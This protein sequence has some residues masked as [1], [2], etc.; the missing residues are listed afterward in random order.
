[1]PSGSVGAAKN[2]VI[3]RMMSIFACLHPDNTKSLIRNTLVASLDQVTGFRALRDGR[4]GATERPQASKQ[5]N[6]QSGATMNYVRA[7]LSIVFRRRKERGREFHDLLDPRP[8]RSS[9]SGCWDVRKG[10]WPR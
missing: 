3:E 2:I 6:A 4:A 1:M 8:L 7:S 10:A 5:P 9:S